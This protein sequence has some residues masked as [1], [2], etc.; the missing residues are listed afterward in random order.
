M[1]TDTTAEY[2]KKRTRD[3]IARFDCLYRA[4]TGTC[5]LEE[6]ILREFEDRDNI[7]PELDYRVYR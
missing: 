2:A 7:F 5:A 4:L 3:H 6:P 1:K